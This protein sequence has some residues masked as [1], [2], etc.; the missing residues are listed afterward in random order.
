MAAG[1]QEK[2]NADRHMRRYA[3]P[4]REVWNAVLAELERSPR[5]ELVEA[6][7]RTRELRAD[8]WGLILRAHRPVRVVMGLDEEGGTVV[9]LHK[10]GDAAAGA[11][12]RTRGG[13]AFLRRLDRRLQGSAARRREP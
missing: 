1:R 8:T 5:W 4:Y 2:G 3:V 12:L 9:A 11:V 7:P 6:D 13:A 10:P